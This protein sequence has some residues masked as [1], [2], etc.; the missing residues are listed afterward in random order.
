MSKHILFDAQGKIS[1]RYNSAIHGDK[2]PD[3]AIL[4]SDELFF[5][6]INET[7]GVW[8]LNAD[9]SITK[10]PMPPA[11]VIPRTQFTSLEFLDRFTEDEQLAVVQATMQSAEVKLWYDRLLAA[12][13]IDLADPRTEAGID[14]LIS[15]GL[16]S[17][18]RKAALLQPA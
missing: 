4:V 17:A 16:I 15:A 6:T 9:G 11:P 13:F 10:E 8:V 2:I 7:D 3:D 1:A 12:S 14:A 5:Q 18:D